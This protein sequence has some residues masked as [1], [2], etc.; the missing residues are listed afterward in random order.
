M[1]TEDRIKNLEFRMQDKI[2]SLNQ[3]LD[4]YTKKVNDIVVAEEPKVQDVLKLTGVTDITKEKI[5]GVCVIFILTMYLLH[6]YKPDFITY[7]VKNEKTFFKERIISYPLLVLYSACI[8]VVIILS[9]LII[10]I[11]YKG[12]N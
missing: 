3:K 2:D 6:Y 9:I 1:S 5:I 12:F 4:L 7:S 10:Y 11:V 8:S